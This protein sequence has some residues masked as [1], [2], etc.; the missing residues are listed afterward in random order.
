MFLVKV[1]SFSPKD[2]LTWT[3]VAN[4]QSMVIPLRLHTDYNVSPFGDVAVGNKPPQ[5][6]LEEQGAA[7]QGPVATLDKAVP[8][9]AS[10]GK[11]IDLTAWVTDD[12]K[13][14]ER[15]ERPDAEPAT[16]GGV[17]LVELLAVRAT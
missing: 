4:G 5:L 10:V 16:A 8:R 2:R 14:L 12:A 1:K 17:H 3:I 6:R 11:P 13:Y 9:T 15:I 7:L